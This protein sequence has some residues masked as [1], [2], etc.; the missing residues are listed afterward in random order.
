MGSKG[1][2]VVGL[3]PSCLLTL[4]DE[5]QVL[6]PSDDVKLLAKYA[7]LFEEFIESELKAE[8]ASLNLVEARCSEAL[9]T[10]IVIKKRLARWPQ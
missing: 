10:D 3:E 2:P 9:F 8:R 1:I 4:R 6:L 5:F 7:F